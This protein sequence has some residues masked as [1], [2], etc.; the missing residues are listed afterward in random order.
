MG[1]GDWKYIYTKYGIGGESITKD[2]VNQS[3]TG[4]KNESQTGYNH[5]WQSDVQNVHGKIKSI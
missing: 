3:L 2:F 5:E 4:V 1:T